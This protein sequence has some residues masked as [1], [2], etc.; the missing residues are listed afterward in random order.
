MRFNFNNLI[1][2]QLNYNNYNIIYLNN[3]IYLLK[4]IMNNINT[5]LNFDIRKNV[6][7]YNKFTNMIYDKFQFIAYHFNN[8]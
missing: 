1:I 5:S 2:Y 7:F 3:L 6:I 8:I 4:I